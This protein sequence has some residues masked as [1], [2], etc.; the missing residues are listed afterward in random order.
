MS[1]NTSET[2]FLEHHPYTDSAVGVS[3][4]EEAAVR[5]LDFDHEEENLYEFLA[6]EIK[7]ISGASM[8]AINSHDSFRVATTR[9]LV[10]LP[11]ILMDLAIRTGNNPTHFKIPINESTF[12]FLKS[13][14]LSPIKNLYTLALGTVP[15]A[16]CKTAETLFAFGE[17]YQVGFTR[18]ERVFG[19]CALIFKK[20]KS[21]QNQ[22]LLMAFIRMAAIALQNKDNEDKLRSSE[23]LYRQMF[24]HGMIGVYRSNMQGEILMANESFHKMYGYNTLEEFCKYDAT[25]FYSNP[26]KRKEFVKR[27]ETQGYVNQFEN[28]G[29]SKQ[30]ETIHFMETAR[31]IV[32]KDGAPPH[33]EGVVVDLTQ[34]RQM[35]WQLKQIANTQSHQIRRP[36]ATLMGLV[37]ITLQTKDPEEQHRF[38][39]LLQQASQDLDQVIHEIVELTHTQEF[40]LGEED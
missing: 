25:K 30:G 11:K 18:R 23:R 35:N 17:I 10:G 14:E 3:F 12:D 31:K 22:D 26:E 39:G 33:Y 2:T 34:V 5:L 4:L 32:P 7:R 36:L 38:L 29:I 20:G 27:M 28:T 19:G 13:G 37:N 8:V 6:H 9:S 15:K 21:L 40:D 24:D 16:V 1:F